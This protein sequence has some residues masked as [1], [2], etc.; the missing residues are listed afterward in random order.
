[1]SVE[2]T[3]NNCIESVLFGSK[4]CKG[5]CSVRFINILIDSSVFT[6]YSI[7]KKQLASD[8]SYQTV[9]VTLDISAKNIW[10]RFIKYFLRLILIVFLRNQFSR[11]GYLNYGDF[12]FYPNISNFYLT[13]KCGTSAQ[14]YAESHLVLTRL[15]GFSKILNIGLSRLMGSSP[16]LS[17]ISMVGKKNESP[18]ELT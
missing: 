18:S 6:K 11:N 5:S 13:Y 17:E 14:Q 8:S 9:I 15:Q 7:L 12:I 4:K 16:L 10:T 1:M 2:V 3:N